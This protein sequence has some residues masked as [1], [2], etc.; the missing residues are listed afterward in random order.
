VAE[1]ENNR[2]LGYLTGTLNHTQ[3][4]EI[5]GLMDFWMNGLGRI[6]GWIFVWRGEKYGD[7]QDACPTVMGRRGRA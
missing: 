1:R 3:E 5:F 2:A 7:R 6:G 4:G